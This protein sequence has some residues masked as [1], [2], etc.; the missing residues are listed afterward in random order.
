MRDVSSVQEV[1]KEEEIRINSTRRS[2]C[3]KR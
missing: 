3:V 2:R 1:M